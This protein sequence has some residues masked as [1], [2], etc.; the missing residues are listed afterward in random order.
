[1]TLN[2]ALMFWFTD[3]RFPLF[4]AAMSMSL[5]TD[6]PH[7]PL[8]YKLSYYFCFSSPSHPTPT[9]IVQAHVE[10]HIDVVK[11]YL[12]VFQKG[13]KVRTHI[14]WTGCLLEL[15]QTLHT[16]QSALKLPGKWAISTIYHPPCSVGHRIVTLHLTV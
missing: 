11:Q 12:F 16:S 9:M 7:R 2:L 14:N 5:R 1:M 3:S 4:F 13:E 6:P 10:R 8:L 15:S